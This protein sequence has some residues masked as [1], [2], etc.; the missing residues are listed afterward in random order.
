MCDITIQDL[1]HNIIIVIW[2]QQV[3]LWQMEIFGHAEFVCI[4][5]NKQAVYV[6]CISDTIIVGVWD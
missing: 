2:N 3:A 5:F 6:I 1:I 4:P